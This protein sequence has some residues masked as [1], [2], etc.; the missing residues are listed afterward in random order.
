M[1]SSSNSF[2]ILASVDSTNNYAFKQI[3]DKVAKHGDAWFS[4]EQLAGKGRRGKSWKAEKGKNIILSIAVNADFL[5][6]Y[7]QF[8]LNVAVSLASLDIFKKYAGDETKIKWPNDIL[9]NDRKAGGIL[10]EN[11]IKGNMWQWAVIGIG[12]N[13]NQTAF[14]VDT[15]FKPVSLK[16][17]TGKE[18]DVIDLA[19]DL[20]Q[21]ILRRYRDLQNNG[22]EKML[23]EYNQNLYGLDKTVKLKK[24]TAVFETIIKG[25]SGG[26]KLITADTMERQFDFDEVEWIK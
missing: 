9:W 23:A 16:Q 11:I 24:D 12:I 18:F 19:K 17:I 10:I 7:Q 15:V 14:N 2:A 26:G 21:S 13:I 3:R 20:H 22:F 25:V 8:Y 4:Y 6:I 1:D 5:T